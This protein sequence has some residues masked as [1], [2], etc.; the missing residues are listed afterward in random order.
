MHACTF[1]SII[2]GSYYRPAYRLSNALAG[3]KG[4]DVRSVRLTATMAVMQLTAIFVPIVH[5]TFLKKEPAVKKSNN[6][7]IARKLFFLI[8]YTFI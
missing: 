7:F 5:K 6:A 4:N 2:Y 8:P 3:G 1:S